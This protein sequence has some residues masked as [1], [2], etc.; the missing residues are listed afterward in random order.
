MAC[1]HRRNVTPVSSRPLTETGET[2]KL[3]DVRSGLPLVVLALAACASFGAGCAGGSM[4]S[5]RLKQDAASLGSFAAEGQ[6]LAQA[7]AAGRAP[8]PYTASHASELGAD[9]GD[10]ASVVSSTH[11]SAGEASG[12]AGVLLLARRTCAL[13]EALEQHPNDAEQAERI[14]GAFG[15][16]TE[17]ASKIERGA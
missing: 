9:C 8:A 10:L 15:T 12:R 3:R 16:I 4:T 13:L 2:R 7:A 14:A 1:T 6:L 5:Y 11:A 17:E